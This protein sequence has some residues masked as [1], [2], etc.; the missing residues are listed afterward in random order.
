MNE[1]QIQSIIDVLANGLV[2]FSGQERHVVSSSE[3]SFS[4]HGEQ[5]IPFPTYPGLQWHS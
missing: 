3:Y 1:V 2:E 5:L 4:P